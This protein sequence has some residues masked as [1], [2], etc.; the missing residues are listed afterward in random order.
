MVRN[1]HILV[2]IIQSYANVTCGG[3]LKNNYKQS[4]IS[5]SFHLLTST[6]R[7]LFSIL[8]YFYLLYHIADNTYHLIQSLAPR[9]RCHSIPRQRS[10]S[11][12]MKYISL[13]VSFICNSLSLLPSLRNNSNNNHGAVKG[14]TH[15]QKRKR[16]GE[17]LL[18]V[19]RGCVDTVRPSSDTATELCPAKTCNINLR[20]NKYK[21]IV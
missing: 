18:V 7:K 17:R 16:S 3:V 21:R 11:G 13:Y 9:T 19:N 15:T 20:R 1:C 10:F 5:F 6:Y 2:I 12:L 14:G 4:N 8:L